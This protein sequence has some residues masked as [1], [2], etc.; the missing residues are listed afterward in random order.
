MQAIKTYRC[1]I[2]YCSTRKMVDRVAA[3]LASEGL[4]PITYHGA[5][6]DG[7]RT[8]AQDRFMAE[9]TPLV[10]AT[11]AF[12]MGVD[13]SDLRFVV[14][15]DIPGSL[16]AYYQEVGRAGRDGASAWCELLFNFAD[17][18]TRRSVIVCILLRLRPLS[19][20]CAAPTDRVDRR[21]MDRGPEGSELRDPHEGT[22]RRTTH[23]SSPAR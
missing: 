12:G 19:V 9:A 21:T 13:R 1:G 15:W 14:H 6:T 8:A 18:H 16:E 3:R 22:L 7:E 20:P 11:N 10:V 4:A 2:V 5:M 17:V 23:R